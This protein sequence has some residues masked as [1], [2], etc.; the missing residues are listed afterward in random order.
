MQNDVYRKKISCL[1]RQYILETFMF[2]FHVQLWDSTLWNV[3]C[4]HFNMS[5]ATIQGTNISHPG[6]RTN[7]L[8]RADMLVP[9]SPE[10]NLM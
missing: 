5:F 2:K 1:E 6:K 8:Q 10:G 9:N 3:C 4:H 7:N